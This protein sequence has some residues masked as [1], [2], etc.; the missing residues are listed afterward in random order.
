MDYAFIA[1]DYIEVWVKQNSGG[2]LNVVATAYS[3][4]FYGHGI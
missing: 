3:P 2:A 4:V 1:G